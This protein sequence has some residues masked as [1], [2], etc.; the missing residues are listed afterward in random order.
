MQ[1][2]KTIIY[3]TAYSVPDK[4]TCLPK[5]MMEYNANFNED[6]HACFK[7]VVI[8]HKLWNCGVDKWSCWESEPPALD[9]LMSKCQH[10]TTA[11]SF[12]HINPSSFP[13]YSFGCVS[14]HELMEFIASSIKGNYINTFN[15]PQRCHEHMN[16][17]QH[18]L[19]KLSFQARTNLPSSLTLNDL[20]K[21]KPSLSRTCFEFEI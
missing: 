18:V 13:L 6:R 9:R 10:A 8:K 5:M 12:I 17:Y 20:I 21:E 19:V 3:S 1:R 11:C 14:H 15:I 4:A 16:F 7:I 2:V